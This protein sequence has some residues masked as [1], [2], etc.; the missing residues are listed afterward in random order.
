MRLL[1]FSH[2]FAPSVG[3][4]ES[5]SRLLAEEWTR[6]GHRV[7][8]VTFTTHAGMDS[9]PYRVVRNPTRS[10]WRN[11]LRESDLCVHNHISLQ[12]AAHLLLTPVPWGVILQ[13][14]LQAY[15]APPGPAGLAKQAALFLAH[16]RLAISPAVAE[17][18][19]A[20]SQL[21]GNAYDHRVFYPDQTILRDREL[22]FLGRL[23]SDKGAD[24]LIE[25]LGLLAGRGLRP[26]LSLVGDGPERPRLIEQAAALGLSEQV[27][28]TGIVQGEALAGLLRRHEILVVPS[29]WPEP[30][31]IVALEGMACGCVPV[32]SDGGGLP[33]AVGAAGVSFT[34]NS[35]SSLALAVERLLADHSRLAGLRGHAEAH[36]A[37]FQ[38]QTVARETLLRLTDGLTATGL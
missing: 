18:L 9:Y 32:V 37:R 20:P 29:R 35:A 25:A 16:A 28:F 14:W 19:K 36:L 23:V 10:A 12:A 7:T 8:V 21:Q 17:A 34:R 11:L 33:F 5:H 24:L 27:T 4:I 38:G 3:G 15:G 30:F 22:V 1:L 26:R 31:G 13:T 6:D 2:H